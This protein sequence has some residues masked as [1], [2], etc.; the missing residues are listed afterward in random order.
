MKCLPIPPVTSGVSFQL[1]YPKLSVVCWRRAVLTAPVPVPEA[2]VNE[3][4]DATTYKNNIWI[5]WQILTM[6]SKAIADAMEH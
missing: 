2:T 4:G 6:K 3:Q 1:V 5:S